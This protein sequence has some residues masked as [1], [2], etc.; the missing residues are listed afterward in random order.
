VEED[1]IGYL[2]SASAVTA[3][4]GQNV[5]PGLLPQKGKLPAVAFHKISP[6]YRYT[7]RGRARQTVSL[8]QLDCWAETWG[9][10]RDLARAVID[11]LDDLNAAILEPGY[12]GPFQGAFVEGDPDSVEAGQGPATSGNTNFHNVRLDV[13][14]AH[15]GN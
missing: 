1:F 3:I 11:T 2:L 7:M 14:V 6:G 4:A 8:V 10:A 15:S 9:G 5:K 12:P 13:R